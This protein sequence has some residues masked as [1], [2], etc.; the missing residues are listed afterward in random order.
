MNKKCV[1]TCITGDYDKVNELNNKEIGFDYYLFT[2]NKKI[3]STTWNVIYIN[4]EELDNV[5]LARKIKILGHD[6]LKKYSMLVWIDGSISIKDNLE[7]FIY[8]YCDFNKFDFIGFKHSRRNCLYEEAYECMKLQKDSFS[9]IESQIENYKKQNY[10]VNNGLIE[11]GVFIRKNNT[12]CNKIMKLWFDEVKKF[13]YRDQISFNYI[14][15]KYKLKYDLLNIN[16]Y[17]NDFFECRSHNALKELKDYYVF[18]DNNIVPDH[19]SVMCKQYNVNND[20][21]ELSFTVKKNSDQLKIQFAKFNGIRF[22]D[23]EIY[24]SNLISYNLV[25][26]GQYYDEKIFDNDIPTLILNGRFKKGDKVIIRIRMNIITSDEYIRLI[27]RL[28]RNV[29]SL[30]HEKEKKQRFIMN[31]VLSKLR[32]LK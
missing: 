10:P 26:Y 29:I 22:S 23:L 5:R 13:S 18:F 14:A 24:F 32:L 31:K 15:Y 8:Q 4:D 30:M 6:I 25:N 19:N 2:N 9:I 3:N 12:R 27:K 20:L 1:Y 17:N 28:N 7:E 21:Y 11:T 16:I